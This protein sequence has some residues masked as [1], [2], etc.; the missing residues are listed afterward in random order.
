MAVNFIFPDTSSYK[1]PCR[2]IPAD[3]LS[4]FHSVFV[5]LTSVFFMSDI[6]QKHFNDLDSYLKLLIAS[7]LNSYTE[8][9]F[10]TRHLPGR[11]EHKYDF[12]FVDL[13]AHVFGSKL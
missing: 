9:L 6:S 3:N 8:F 4:K 7:H 1:F 10:D 5:K 11:C 12:S 2:W 13:N